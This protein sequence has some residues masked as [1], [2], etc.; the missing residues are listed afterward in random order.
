MNQMLLAF[1]AVLAVLTAGAPSTTAQQH[2]GVR[3]THAISPIGLH[4]MD[5]FPPTGL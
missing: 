3:P 2:A 1:A 4:P 5:T